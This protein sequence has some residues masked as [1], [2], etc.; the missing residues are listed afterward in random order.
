MTAGAGK[1]IVLRTGGGDLADLVVGNRDTTVGGAGRRRVRPHQGRSRRPF[2]RA[3]NV[4]L[5]A[6]R[7]GLVR[8]RR[9]RREAQRDQED[10]ADRR[11]PRRG[12][13]RTAEKP[14]ELKLANVPEKRVA[15]TFKVSRLATLI[16][17]FTFQDV[18]KATKPADDARR[19]V[20]DADDGLRLVLTSVGDITEGWVQIAV[21]PVDEAKQDTAKTAAEALAAKVGGYDFRLSSNLSE[22]MGWTNLDLTNEQTADQSAGPPPRF[23]PGGPPPGFPL[24]GPPPGF[25]PGVNIR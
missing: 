17:S 16:E 12:R 23:P 14:G 19:M 24:G 11:R 4:R 8:A 6:T 5:P 13:R 9:S 10:R 3:A 1:E 21:A 7:A 22:I 2:W 15:D 20:V 18:R 25:P